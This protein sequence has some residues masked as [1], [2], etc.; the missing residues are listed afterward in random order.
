MRMRTGK[1][2][3]LSSRVTNL[4]NGLYFQPAVDSL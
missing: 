3:D 1:G 2:V 4:E